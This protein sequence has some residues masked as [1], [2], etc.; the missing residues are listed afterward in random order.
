MGRWNILKGLWRPF[1]ENQASV[2]ATS[3]CYYILLSL[4]PASMLLSSLLPRL[5]VS[6]RAIQQ[7]LTQLIPE[8][9]L[10]L[11]PLLFPFTGSPV[12]ASA[13]ALVLLWSASK[14]VM[15]ISDGLCALT[16]AELRK[17]FFRRKLGAMVSF[18][19]LAVLL[20]LV[21]ILYVFGE[22][23]AGFLGWL[24]APA[25][26]AGI[27]AVAY[28]YLPGHL[29]PFRYCLLGGVFAA[30]G[31]VIF[32]S[33]FSLYVSF[34]NGFRLRYGSLGLV[35]LACIWLQFCISL[36]LYGGQLSAL[37]FRREYHPLT[38]LKAWVKGKS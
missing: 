9:F 22:Y 8:Q 7:S 5:P 1:T 31:W 26:L 16:G 20:I 6:A 2:Y 25:T 30:G 11:L 29:L 18:L 23:L 28:R 38:I 21:L 35:L 17:G 15:A 27:F 36:L 19:L 37:L 10:S 24:F 34:A 33:L 14:G 4:L 12:L 13:S 3:A 32:S